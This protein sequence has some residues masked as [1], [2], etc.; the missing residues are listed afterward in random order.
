MEYLKVYSYTKKEIFYRQFM[1]QIGK[2]E[3][4][5]YVP[6]LSFVYPNHM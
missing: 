1:I 3:E 6:E 5:T 2:N 4:G